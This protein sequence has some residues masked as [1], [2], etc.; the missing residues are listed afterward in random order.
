G[1]NS[2]GRYIKFGDGTMICCRTIKNT[3][4]TYSTTW[5]YPKKFVEIPSVSVNVSVLNS[6]GADIYLP[7]TNI[8]AISASAVGIHSFDAKT[9]RQYSEYNLC[10][11]AIGRW[12]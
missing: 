9:G 2:Y 4:N 8:Y 3:R 12:K 11:I 7:V 6:G 5:T 10:L 1:N